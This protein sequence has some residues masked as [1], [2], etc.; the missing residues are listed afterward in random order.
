MYYGGNDSLRVWEGNVDDERHVIVEDETLAQGFTQIPNG[1]LRRSDLQP[2]AKLTYMVLLSYAWQKDHAYP[3]Q[4]RLATDMGVSERSVI[5]YL[6]QLSASGLITI[7]RRG[8]GKTNIYVLH[9]I[10]GSENL[11]DQRS[12]RSAPP[13]VKNET[14]LEVKNLPTKNTQSKK[15]QG[16]PLEFRK[17]NPQEYDEAREWLFPYIDDFAREF[18]DQAPRTSTLTRVVKLYRRSGLDQDAFV[19]LLYRARQTTKE[20]TGNVR[21][22][23][24][25]QK[26]L[27]GYFLAVLERLVTDAA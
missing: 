27:I 24:G 13:D 26:N 9:R 8:L 11:A 19:D 17:A 18:R 1:V 6:K 21:A 23:E 5:T 2:G 3:G 12:E 4:D 20:R 7:H 10:T 15:T 22:G 25:G 16:E 14:A